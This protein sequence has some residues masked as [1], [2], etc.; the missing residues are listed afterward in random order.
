MKEKMFYLCE[1]EQERERLLTP[2]L[3]S[4]GMHLLHVA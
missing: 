3:R 1:R 4:G 2:L